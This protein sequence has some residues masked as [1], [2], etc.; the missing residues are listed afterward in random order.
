MNYNFTHPTIVFL[1]NWAGHSTYIMCVVTYYIPKVC[2]DVC[3]PGLKSQSYNY[4]AHKFSH[5]KI[6]VGSAGN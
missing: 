4:K 2:F 5:C 6:Y 1:D 3:K